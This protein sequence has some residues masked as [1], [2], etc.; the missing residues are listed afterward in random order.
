MVMDFFLE[1][2]FRCFH[3][4]FYLG[5]N[6]KQTQPPTPP[7]P[8][9]PKPPTNPINPTNEENA[10]RKFLEIRVVRQNAWELGRRNKSCLEPW[11]HPATTTAAIAGVFCWRE[12]D[13]LLQTCYWNVRLDIWRFEL[14]YCRCLKTFYFLNLMLLVML[15]L[16]FPLIW[17]SIRNIQGELWS[18][19]KWGYNISLETSWY[20]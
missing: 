3:F 16:L 7:T 12:E 6:K 17:A 5:I 4:G 20:S 1:G 8:N 14:S 11:W 9:Q 13:C 15:F 19:Q 2:I 10:H 18:S